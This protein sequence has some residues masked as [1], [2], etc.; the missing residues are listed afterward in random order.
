MN[1]HLLKGSDKQF[2]H[3]FIPIYDEELSKLVHC[4]RILEF[5]VFKGESVRWLDNKFPNTE[6]FAADIL[7][8]QPEWPIANNIKYYYVDQGS[9]ETIKTLFNSIGNELDLIIEDGSHL[10]NHQ[11]NCLI[12]SFKHL[13]SGGIYILEDLHTS[14]P[15][16]PYYKKMGSNYI[17]PFHLLLCFEHLISTEKDLDEATLKEISSKSLFN[18]EDIRYLFQRISNI[19]IYKRA[20]LPHK[21]Y[22]CG[23][24]DF[25]YHKIACKCG[26]GIYSPSDSITAII[27]VK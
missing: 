1:E 13:S 8:I 21:C 10:P 2:W 16:H 9:P 20:T 3:R 12:E 18:S 23:S 26:I 24:T 19:K 27:T 22:K 14:H 15:E 11:K 25:N 17:G 6:I 5:G 7:T 4:N